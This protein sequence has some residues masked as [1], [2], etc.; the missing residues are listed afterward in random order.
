M[1]SPSCGYERLDVDF[2]GVRADDADQDAGDQFA[3]PR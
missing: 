1:A 2:G 3:E